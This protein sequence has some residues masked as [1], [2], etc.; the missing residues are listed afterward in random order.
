[1]G[2]TLEG[3]CICFG[4]DTIRRR[5]FDRV[6]ILVAAGILKRIAR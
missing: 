3:I 6:F 5:R 1:M 2:V 4:H